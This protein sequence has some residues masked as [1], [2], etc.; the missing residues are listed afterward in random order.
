MGFMSGGYSSSKSKSTQDYSKTLLPQQQQGLESLSSFG[1]NMLSGA[2]MDPMKAQAKQ[3]INSQFDAM[4]DNITQRLSAR[5]MG[6]Q[7]G[8][9][10]KRLTQMD[11]QRAGAQAGAENNFAQMQLDQQA[12]GANVLQNL[13]SQVFGFKQSGTSSQSGFSV[14]GGVGR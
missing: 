4:P 10:L 8:M 9:L 6:D 3:N 1:Q 11:Y 14:S 5:G 12:Q 2:N 13:L 7:S